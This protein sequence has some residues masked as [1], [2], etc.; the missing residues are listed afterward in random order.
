MILKMFVFVYFH[1]FLQ[2]KDNEI[3]AFLKNLDMYCLSVKKNFVVG[4]AD[5]RKRFRLV[6]KPTKFILARQPADSLAIG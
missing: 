1:I 4:L 5:K 3:E 6:A 2:H